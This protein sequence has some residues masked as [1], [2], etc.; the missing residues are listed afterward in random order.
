MF[1]PEEKIQPHREENMKIKVFL[2]IAIVFLSMSIFG[3]D[4]KQRFRDNKNGTLTDTVTGYTW[5]KAPDSEL[6]ITWKEAW[7]YAA[8]LK[9]GGLTG[10]HLPSKEDLQALAKPGGDT[11]SDWLNSQGFEGIQWGFYWTSTTD[12]KKN[13]SAFYVDL[14]SGA[15]GSA[16]KENRYFVIAI[17]KPPVPAR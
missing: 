3:A 5:I 2:L 6:T 17:N 12:T 10:W 4:T 13:D 15:G 8:K 11:P 1:H 9:T 16:G 14:G 7:D